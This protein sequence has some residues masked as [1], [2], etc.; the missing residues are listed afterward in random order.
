M[1][2]QKERIGFT[3]YIPYTWAWSHQ[4]YL[5]FVDVLLAS[6]SSADWVVK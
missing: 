2:L 6:I 5:L 4:L 1:F 3:F